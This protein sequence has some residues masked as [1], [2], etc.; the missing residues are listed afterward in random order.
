MKKVYVH[1]GRKFQMV[2][3]EVGE[4][5]CGVG[6][7]IQIPVPTVPAVDVAVHVN[8]QHVNRN[9]VLPV[10]VDHLSELSVGVEPVPRVPVAIRVAGEQGN[11]SG[12]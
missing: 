5:L 3:V 1:V 12:E 2:G 8:A 9:A 6:K 10:V 4:H 11:R 7:Q